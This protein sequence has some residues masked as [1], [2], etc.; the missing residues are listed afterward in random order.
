MT[1]TPNAEAAEKQLRDWA[2]N[3]AERDQL[4]KAARAAGVSKN[5]IHTLTGISRSTIDRILDG[6]TRD[7]LPAPAGR[8]AEL[9]T[10]TGE[11]SR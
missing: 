6:D 11:A 5:R 10:T 7:P 2:R 9:R 1:E 4:V 3:N 8:R